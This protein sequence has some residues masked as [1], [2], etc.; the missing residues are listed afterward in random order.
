MP[1]AQHHYFIFTEIG[2]YLLLKSAQ[3]LG[4]K[5][6]NVLYIFYQYCMPVTTQEMVQ[7]P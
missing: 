6:F 7:I 5:T 2:T 4:K 1:A 3:K